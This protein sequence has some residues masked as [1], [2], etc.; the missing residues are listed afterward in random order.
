MFA[1]IRKVAGYIILIVIVPFLVVT[2]Y[3][4]FHTESS[5]R[6]SWYL[7]DC[8]M[9]TNPLD[10]EEWDTPIIGR[11]VQIGKKR[12]RYQLWME[13]TNSWSPM[14][15]LKEMSNGLMQAAY[16]VPCPTE[17]SQETR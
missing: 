5:P 16:R 12:F 10:L 11:V 6:K 3:D 7:H 9:A 4:I 1:S 17:L 14:D 2:L 8:F 13:R 15:D